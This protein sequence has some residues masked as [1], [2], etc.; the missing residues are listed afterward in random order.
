MLHYRLFVEVNDPRSGVEKKATEQL[1]L[2]L[3]GKRLDADA[4][5]LGTEVALSEHATGSLAESAR[6]DGARSLRSVITENNATTGR[7]RTQLTVDVPGT[8]RSKP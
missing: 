7:W 6:P 5:T 2:W 1:H 4:L 8:T 3:R